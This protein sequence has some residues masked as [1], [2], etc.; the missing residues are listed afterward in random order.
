MQ[1]N[2]FKNADKT[3]TAS[4]GIQY[5][6]HK[7]QELLKLSSDENSGKVYLNQIVEKIRRVKVLGTVKGDQHIEHLAFRTSFTLQNIFKYSETVRQECSAEIRYFLTALKSIALPCDTENDFIIT[8]QEIHDPEFDTILTD[9]LD[10]SKET[11]SGEEEKCSKDFFHEIEINI[12]ENEK[13]QIKADSTINAHTNGIDDHSQT[14]VQTVRSG[15]KGSTSLHRDGED[16]ETSEYLA[17]I[18]EQIQEIKKLGITRGDEY[19]VKLAVNTTIALRNILKYGRFDSEEINAEYQYFLTAL[20]SLSINNEPISDST[21]IQKDNVDEAALKDSH[22]EYVPGDEAVSDDHNSESDE[23]FESMSADSEPPEQRETSDDENDFDDLLAEQAEE[24]DEDSESGW[25]ENMLDEEMKEDENSSEK[26]ALFQEV[27]EF[28]NDNEGEIQ[29]D[30][31]FEKLELNLNDENEFSF[32]DDAEDGLED[33]LK[34]N[35]KNDEVDETFDNEKIEVELNNAFEILD[36]ASEQDDTISDAD[37]QLDDPV[38]MAESDGPRIDELEE[39]VGN[40]D[41]EE[42]ADKQ[43]LSDDRNEQDKDTLAEVEK[44]VDEPSGKSD[45]A[46]LVEEQKDTER[47]NEHAVGPD[48]QAIPGDSEQPI[49]T[50][51]AAEMEAFAGN[52]SEEKTEV[53]SDSADS[54]TEVA[55]DEQS[56]GEN[57]EEEEEAE[58]AEGESESNAAIENEVVSQE[59]APPESSDK[60]EVE[61]NNEQAAEAEE[62]SATLEVDS[63]LDRAEK[64]EDIESS[65]L[66]E[67]EIEIN[68]ELSSQDATEESEVD[69]ELYELNQSRESQDE[70]ADIVENVKTDTESIKNENENQGENENAYSVIE[71]ETASEENVRSLSVGKDRQDDVHTNEKPGVAVA[72]ADEI[73]ENDELERSTIAESDPQSDSAEKERPAEQFD[74]E[75]EKDAAE[76]SEFSF[77]ENLKSDNA[78]IGLDISSSSLKIAVLKKDE[79]GLKLVHWRIYDLDPNESEDER[80][81]NIKHVW[82]NF[83]SRYK[84]LKKLPVVTSLI[85]NSV[86]IRYITLP[87]MSDANFVRSA[88]LEFQAE[89]FFPEDQVKLITYPYRVQES[90]NGKQKTGLLLAIENHI[91]DQI[92]T[93]IKNASIKISRVCIDSFALAQYFNDKDETV[94]AVID[95]G[96]DKVKIVIIHKREIRFARNIES[97][98][99]SVTAEIAEYLGVDLN[100]AENLKHQIRF[101]AIEDD[102]KKFS[103]KL[104]EGTEG[105]IQNVAFP[106]Y[107]KLSDEIQLTLQ[108]YNSNNEKKVECV[109]LVGG[110][111][112]LKGFDKFL[113]H[114]LKLPVTVADINNR[115]TVPNIHNR[116]SMLGR[117]SPKLVVATGLALSQI[118]PMELLTK[119]DLRKK[120]K[121]KK[122]KISFGYAKLLIPVAALVIF[123]LG[124]QMF[125][126]FQTSKYE[127]NM[128]M[129]KK[130]AAEMALTIESLKEYEVLK[131]KLDAQI[132]N[133]RSLKLQQP[134]WSRVMKILSQKIPDGIWLDHFIGKYETIIPEVEEEEMSFGDE[135]MPESEEEIDKNKYFL[136]LSLKGATTE[137][138][139]IQEFISR[140]EKD[141]SYEPIHFSKIINQEIPKS[142]ITKFDADGKVDISGNKK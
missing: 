62:K 101:V 17:Q 52:H 50:N 126:K 114:T 46:A 75:V 10:D 116:S 53:E 73:K 139:R 102:R 97:Y 15:E 49:E 56:W 71:S 86:L 88:A 42:N 109:D 90:K 113:S 16:E 70:Q 4:E 135:G 103:L 77:D 28:L 95:L 20:N 92:L 44:N 121:I 36:P 134:R 128:E 108:Y 84:Q 2:D 127:K 105:N 8:E 11:A 34:E 3:A 123:T 47:P 120:H 140:V 124:V 19:I 45:S 74:Q 37:E 137:Q 57:D 80:I 5:Y 107:S 69:G 35:I 39:I 48:M 60:N 119:I 130:I 40:E 131:G 21:K 9:L 59:L 79:Q 115:L 66:Q 129:K 18:S 133:I 27:Q 94:R 65:D 63:Q 141:D 111:A 31:S 82:A 87:N 118:A 110:G 6:I 136:N 58:A 85:D 76:E 132:Q 93:L 64:D 61:V 41:I 117:I 38:E 54:Q 24:D 142:N 14:S 99:K 81:N 22:A 106:L 1:N 68:A 89:L 72:V 30:E 33:I 122:E 7:I 32:T 78:A 25:F 138:Y 51:S 23:I 100:E 55:T 83:L 12:S 43:S 67:S 91:L 125:F 13:P 96:A 26:D 112:L 98:E 29:S 104:P